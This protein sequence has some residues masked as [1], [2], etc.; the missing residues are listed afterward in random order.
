MGKALLECSDHLTWAL[1]MATWFLGLVSDLCGD[2]ATVPNIPS[3]I[4]SLFLT[5]Y[6][7]FF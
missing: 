4:L 2:G 7:D 6:D 3:S 5:S 1:F